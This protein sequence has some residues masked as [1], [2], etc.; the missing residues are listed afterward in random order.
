[1]VKDPSYIRANRV[2]PLHL[3]I[4]KINR[5]IEKSN[6]SK[7]LTLVPADESKDTLKKYEE[8]WKK[9]LDVLLDG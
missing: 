3:I 7:Y 5:N 1:M 2:N 4:D 6:G 8:L 9:K